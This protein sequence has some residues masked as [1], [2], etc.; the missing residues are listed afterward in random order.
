[1]GRRWWVGWF[2]GRRLRVFLLALLGN[3]NLE[4]CEWYGMGLLL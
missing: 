4:I 2:G 3:G 1:V